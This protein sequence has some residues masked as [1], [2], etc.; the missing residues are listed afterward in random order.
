MNRVKETVTNID[1]HPS[2]AVLMSVYKSEQP[3]F[4]VES[5]ESIQHQTIQPDQIVIV[6]DG[7]LTPELDAT[8]NQ[9]QQEWGDRCK[10]ITLP[11]NRG[12]GAALNKGTKFV[13]SEW[14][15]RMDSDD[16][17]VSDRFA[18]Q[19]TAINANPDV[20]L[21]GGQIDEF[22]QQV[23]E[24]LGKREV[25]CSTNQIRNFMKYRS[26]FNHPTVMIKTAVLN[27]VGGYQ[28]DGKLED[29]FLW[30][31]VIATGQPV[32]NVPETL[33]HMRVGAGMYGRRGDWSNLRHIFRLRR[34]MKK[35][36]LISTR[37]EMVGDLM[38]VGNIVVPEKVRE[39]VY[40]RFLHK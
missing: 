38:Q 40:K 12:L 13:T 19:L 9:Y 14:V 27:E 3:Q 8:L 36:G 20:V 22:D 11:Q 37:E 35:K 6:K 17:A 1:Q 30:A 24:V 2:F 5:L 33:V 28:A 10:L 21:V 26:P 16:I 39:I 23:D 7:P 4:L 29:Y 32:L 15:A 25:P 34:F 31:R 18:I